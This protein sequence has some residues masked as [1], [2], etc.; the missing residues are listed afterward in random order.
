MSAYLATVNQP[1]GA[2]PNN[3]TK[4]TPNTNIN[5]LSI[6]LFI[7]TYNTTLNYMTRTIL[8]KQRKITTL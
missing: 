2:M 6:L 7:L 5:S 8:R 4:T 3:E 1:I